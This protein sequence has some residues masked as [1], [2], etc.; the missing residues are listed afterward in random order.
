MQ[1]FLK[2][3]KFKKARPH[4]EKAI[5]YL[6]EKTPPKIQAK[7]MCCFLISFSLLF[8]RKKLLIN[9]SQNSLSSKR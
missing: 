9:F 1:N 5:I 2:I 4:Q 6:L 7:K 8:L 3:S